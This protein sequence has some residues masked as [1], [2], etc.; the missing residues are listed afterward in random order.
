MEIQD[1]GVNDTSNDLHNLTNVPDE[2]IEW[3]RKQSKCHV[4]PQKVKPKAIMI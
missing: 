1:R 2:L 4:Y 3:R